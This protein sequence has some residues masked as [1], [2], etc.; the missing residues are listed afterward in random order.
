MIVSIKSLIKFFGVNLFLIFLMTFSSVIFAQ[1][2]GDNG[3]V[4]GCWQTVDEKTHTLSSVIEIKPSGKYFI[5]TIVKTYPKPGEKP[6]RCVNCKGDAKN[7]PTLG[8]T[9]IHNMICA[10]GHCSHGTILDPRDGKIYHASLQLING[11]EF[12]KVRGYI[13][14]PLLGRTVIWHRVATPK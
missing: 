5:G 7:K 10:S 14:I 8:L 1:S 6:S 4:A 12:I 3:S 11:G 2:L 13:G 9:I